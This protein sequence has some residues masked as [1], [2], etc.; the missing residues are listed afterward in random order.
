MEG[1]RIGMQAALGS[2]AMFSFVPV[3]RSQHSGSA[4]ISHQYITISEHVN[5]AEA[6]GAGLFSY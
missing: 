5:E 1:R 6:G 4:P 2:F 3:S